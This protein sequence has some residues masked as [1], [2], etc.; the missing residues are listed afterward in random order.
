MFPSKPMLRRSN[1]L[2]IHGIDCVQI[3]GKWEIVI[4]ATGN[5][6]VLVEPRLA[7]A[8]LGSKGLESME[9]EARLD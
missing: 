1:K 5:F 3:V 6:Q 7:G 9:G 4:A 8:G 2:Q